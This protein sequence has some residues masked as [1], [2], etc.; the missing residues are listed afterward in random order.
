MD[1]ASSQLLSDTPCNPLISCSCFVLR[2]T[3]RSRG[4]TAGALPAGG[5]R[6]GEGGTVLVQ[7]STIW[8]AVGWLV[9]GW[10]HG[11]EAFWASAPR[12]TCPRGEAV[13]GSVLCVTNPSW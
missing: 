5:E 2:L 10:G 6:G 1:V 3:A 9:G 11:H 8:D 4:E 13:A 12:A 7:L